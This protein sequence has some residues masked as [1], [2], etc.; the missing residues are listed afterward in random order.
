[1]NVNKRRDMWQASY[2]SLVCAS[3]AVSY[4]VYLLVRIA[5]VICAKALF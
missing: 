2:G 4:S 5:S 1:M 3:L